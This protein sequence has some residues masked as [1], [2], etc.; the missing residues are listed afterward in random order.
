M[1]V[2]RV[3]PLCELCGWTR[4]SSLILEF[5]PAR[6]RIIDRCSRF[7]FATARWAQSRSEFSQNFQMHLKLAAPFGPPTIVVRVWQGICYAQGTNVVDFLCHYATPNRMI[8]SRAIA[9]SLPA[10]VAFAGQHVRASVSICRYMACRGIVSFLQALFAPS[11]L[12][13]T[14][15]APLGGAGGWVMGD[16]AETH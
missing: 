1:Y 2:G 3:V 7:R 15:R 11:R 10:C 9:R 4:I 14:V 5:L 8:G 12:M 13:M 6:W 16:G